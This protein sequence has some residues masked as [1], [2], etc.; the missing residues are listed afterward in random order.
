ME[1]MSAML[2]I[3]D[4]PKHKIPLALKLKEMQSRTQSEIGN[5]CNWR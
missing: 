5:V 1:R 4:G 3:V 2:A